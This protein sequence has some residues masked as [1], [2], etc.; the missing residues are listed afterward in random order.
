MRTQ[1]FARI[2]SRRP[3]RALIV[4]NMYPTDGPARRSAASSAIRSRR[5]GG[6]RDVEVEVFAFAPGGAGRL[7]RAPRASS[8]AASAATGSTSSTPIS[9]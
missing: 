8:G 5:S 1:Q 2:R 4:T 9:A 7:R 6:S 3:M